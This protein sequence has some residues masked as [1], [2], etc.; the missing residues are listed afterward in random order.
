MTLRI[1]NGATVLVKL[2]KASSRSRV[3]I[4]SAGPYTVRFRQG[5][6]VVQSAKRV[7]FTKWMYEAAGKP[8]PRQK[9][10]KHRSVR[11]ILTPSGGQ[12]GFHR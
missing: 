6:G 8:V 9:G 7:N 4:V 2:P 11:V 5:T 1:E 3:T 12:P 10:S